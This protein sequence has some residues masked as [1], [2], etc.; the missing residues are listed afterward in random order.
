MC[1]Y[2][3][4][5]HMY[6]QNLVDMQAKLAGAMKKAELEAS[7]KLLSVLPY[8]TG[9]VISRPNA[10]SIGRRN[11][12]DR[13]SFALGD[14]NEYD[15]LFTRMPA[16]DFLNSNN[17]LLDDGMLPQPLV[18]N[19][20]QQRGMFDH[21]AGN[22]PKSVIEGDLSSI[23]SGDWSY[24]NTT[25][26]LANHQKIH[27]K[28]AGSVGSNRPKSADIS[29]WSFGITS[30]VSSSKN[31]REKDSLASPWSGLSPTVSTFNE[32]PQ[33]QQQSERPQSASD[34]DQQLSMIANNWGLNNNN[35]SNSRPVSLSEDSKNF[36]RRTV[37][38]TSIP[39][40][41]PET[42]EH[43]IKNGMQSPPPPTPIALPNQANIVLSMYEESNTP[44]AALIGA[45]E[46]T[47]PYYLIQP[48]NRPTTTSGSSSPVPSQLNPNSVF[49]NRT[50]TTSKSQQAK[51]QQQNYGQFLNPNDRVPE[52]E[53]G[54]LSD[55][56]DASNRSTGSRAMKKKNHNSGYYNNN[57]ARS[58]GSVNSNNSFGTGT[59]NKDKKNLEVVDIKLLEGTL[60]KKILQK[61]HDQ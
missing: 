44:S 41:V 14:T 57:N 50:T 28:Q 2:I 46:T 51:L 55:H 10:N 1:P 5:W 48:L 8:Q 6:K 38:R 56:S 25:G 60:E 16:T 22:R 29:N 33:Q 49:G 13:H 59:N 7:Q 30:S 36:R 4:I 18:R 40:T 24:G 20:H 58:G 37:N 31:I 27:Q 54:Y 52:S 15:R 17:G 23:F 43:L 61:K 45:S 34:V 53:A 42:D 19:Q 47:N 32:Q 9:Q 21:S 39:G 3:D 26:G 12:I 35:N 11:H